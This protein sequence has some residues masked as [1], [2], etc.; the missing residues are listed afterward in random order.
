MAFQGCNDVVISG[1]N[2]VTKPPHFPNS[3]QPTSIIFMGS[4][5]SLYQYN[6]QAKL[7]HWAFKVTLSYWLDLNFI[8]QFD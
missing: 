4:I 6:N 5:L 2:L 8:I 3:F 1:I 7:T